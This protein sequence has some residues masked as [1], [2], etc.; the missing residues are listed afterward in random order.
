[1]PVNICESGVHFSIDPGNE[2][3]TCQRLINKPSLTVM[4]LVQQIGRGLLHV[5]PNLLG[6]ICQMAANPP[7]SEGFYHSWAPFVKC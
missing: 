4:A 2:K 5:T 3:V 6:Q 7:I 1:M